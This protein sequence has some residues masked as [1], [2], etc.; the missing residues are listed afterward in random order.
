[1]KYALL[2]FDLKGIPMELTVYR[3]IALSQMDAYKDYLFLPFTDQTN[4]IET[5]GGGRY[6]DL[7]SGDFENGTIEMTIEEDKLHKTGNVKWSG[8]DDKFCIRKISK[9]NSTKGL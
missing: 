6:L 7:R 5:Y 9:A 2:R 3:S 8:I 4:G 1:V